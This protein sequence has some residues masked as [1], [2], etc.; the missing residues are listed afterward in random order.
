VIY[1][2]TIQDKSLYGEPDVVLAVVDVL[3]EEAACRA[4]RPTI[5]QLADAGRALHSPCARSRAR[6][7]LLAGE[8][9]SGYRVLQA[10]EDF[11]FDRRLRGVLAKGRKREDGQEHPRY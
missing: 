8:R 9:W 4:A 7:V 2:V 10:S 1:L 11:L 3:D 6:E 5:E